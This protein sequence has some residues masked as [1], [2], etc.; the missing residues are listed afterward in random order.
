MYENDL[1]LGGMEQPSTG[2]LLGYGQDRTAL[3]EGEAGRCRQLSHHPG[4]GEGMCPGPGKGLPG[5][6]AFLERRLDLAT[7][8]GLAGLEKS[9][10]RLEQPPPQKE[11]QNQTHH[12]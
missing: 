8:S 3:P 4:K 5:S 9:T 1:R 2:R 11:C 10:V 7:A 12:S 6:L